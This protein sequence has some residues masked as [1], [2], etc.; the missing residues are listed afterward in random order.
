MAA[1]KTKTTKSAPRKKSVASVKEVGSG[2][3]QKMPQSSLTKKQKLLVAGGVLVAIFLLFLGRG[4]F[5]A[6]TVNGVPV[7]R[8]EVIKELE[9][10]GGQQVLDTI[11][12]EKLILQEAKKANL[13]VT[14]E[15]INSKIEGFKEQLT[16]E[17]QDFDSLLE[18]QGISA[19]DFREQVMLQLYLEKLLSDR[20]QLTEEE[21]NSFL[22]ANRDFMP[23][24]LS[25][26][27]MKQLA[28]EELKQ[29]KLSTE[30]AAWLPEL[31]ANANIN[32][33]VEY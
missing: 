11:I 10:Q 14:D 17:G 25:D 31:K 21:V 20:V 5:V 7:S 12:N 8:L 29:Q 6:A 2:S 23:A 13:A 15:E 18:L 19:E 26:D 28:E 32:Y 27:E 24:G 1:R 9:K 33:L 3:F 16:S 4:L 30:F 22:E